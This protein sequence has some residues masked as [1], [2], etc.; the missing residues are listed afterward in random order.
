MVQYAVVIFYHK[1]NKFS[2]NALLGAI[3]DDEEILNNFKFY[4][5]RNKNKLYDS[6]EEIVSIH[7]EV[8]LCFSISTPQF[9]D[10][11]EIVFTLRKKYDKRVLIIA[12][13]PHPTGLPEETFETGFDFIF[14]YEAE[15]SFKEFLKVFITHGDFRKIKGIFFKKDN[16]YIF[17]GRPEFIDIDN[18]MPFSIKFRRFGPIEIT[19]GCNHFCYYCQTPRIFGVKLRHRSIEKILKYVEIL[20]K[21]KKTDI[22]FITPDALSYGSF[23]NEV[24]IDA[25]YSLLKGIREIIKDEG[26]IFFGSF[27]SEIRPEKI[28]EE[29]VSILKKFVDNKMIVIGAQTGSERLLKKIRRGHTVSDVIDAVKILRKNGF[30]VAVDFI[31][32][33]PEENE[34]DIKESIELMKILIKMGAKIHAHTLL[35]LPQ[36]PYFKKD[37]PTINKDLRKFIGKYIPEGV[38]FGA[39]S[40]QEKLAKKIYERFILKNKIPVPRS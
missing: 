20:K 14:R 29:T 4:F 32:G 30:D 12:G 25:V 8:I 35:P 19:R 15:E 39:W 13:G 11:E 3:E 18:Y 10:T 24:N 5:I 17:S 37:L 34:D 1:K 27:P 40:N 23:N 31:F 16:K 2:F 21:Y 22:R 28:K 7:R 36:T 33:F 38:V 26:R 9:F 6:I